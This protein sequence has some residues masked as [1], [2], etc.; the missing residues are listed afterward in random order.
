MTKK[1]FIDGI[2]NRLA[3]EDIKVSKKDCEA[4]I[5]IAL[6]TIRTEV[7]ESDEFSY[8]GFGKFKKVTRAAR[9]GVNPKTHEAIDIP[10]HDAVTFKAAPGFLD[11]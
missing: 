9:K 1:E 5:N 2:V 7:L 6:L 10:E 11:V 8:P 4:C 3:C